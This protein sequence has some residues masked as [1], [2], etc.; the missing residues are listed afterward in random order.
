MKTTVP[1][2][3][4]NLLLAICSV[5]IVLVAAELLLRA[6]GAGGHRDLRT[7]HEVQPDRPWL[8]GLRPGA[9]ARLDVSGDVLYRIN[10]DGFRD[11]VYARPKPAGVFRIA[12]LGD[13]IAF[14][15]GV[16][17]RDSFPERVERAFAAHHGADRIEVVNFGVNAYNA[18][19]EA[20]LFEELAPAFEPDLVLVQFC[21]NDL[22][23]PTL[24]FDSSTNRVLESIPSLAFPNPD[25]RQPPLPPRASLSTVCDGLA[26]CTRLRLLFGDAANAPADAAAWK[27][28][29]AP[30]DG[31]ENVVEWRWLRDRYREIARAA[32]AEGGR[33]VV[34][35]FPYQT[36][37]RDETARLAQPEL[38]RI[39]AEEDWETID[40]LA[41]FRDAARRTSEPLFLD[42]WHP[43]AA[44]HRAAAD[45]IARE[46]AC[47]GLVP[48]EPG[49]ECAS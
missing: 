38:A 30:H 15:Y 25:A 12:V 4:S 46:L 37:I 49:A 40:L 11:R 1:L 6:R 41:A 31:P 29:F 22:N 32:A 9:E 26:L 14:G 39:G 35:A 28:T 43:T 27:A 3:R 23:D 10:A 8:Y 17:E 16:A 5:A 13:S 24:H 48:V 34:L 47:R 42:V 21:V 36:Q 44:G 2:L 20:A 45:A 18:Y 19:N 33:L 7:L